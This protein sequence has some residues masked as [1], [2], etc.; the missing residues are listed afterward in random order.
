MSIGW[1]KSLPS[2][3]RLLSSARIGQASRPPSLIGEM[4]F[5]GLNRVFWTPI[6]LEVVLARGSRT[7]CEQSARERLVR[8]TAG[9]ET[10][11]AALPVANLKSFPPTVSASV[12]Y[13][14]ALIFPFLPWFDFSCG[15]QISP[16]DFLSASAAAMEL[17]CSP[18]KVSLSV[19]LGPP[20]FLLSWY[21]HAI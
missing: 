20:S 5:G 11:V 19:Y 3:V 1:V 18:L 6:Q 14:G 16:S 12:W 8:R 7:L 2:F 4:R 10:T 15:N 9:G 13:F 21:S 17:N